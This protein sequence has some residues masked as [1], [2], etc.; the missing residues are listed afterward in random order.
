MKT[1]LGQT[2]KTRAVRIP[3]ANMEKASLSNKVDQTAANDS[4]VLT[5]SWVR[6]VGWASACARIHKSKDDQLLDAETP[7]ALDQKEWDW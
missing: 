3:V 7:T 1:R 2:G 6:C 5:P 4:V